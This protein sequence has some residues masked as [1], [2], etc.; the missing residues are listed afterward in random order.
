MKIKLT[1]SQY[2]KMLL[3]EFGEIVNDPKDWYVR[4]LDWVSS[5]AELEFDSN[6]Y[7]VVVYDKKWTIKATHLAA[8]ALLLWKKSLKTKL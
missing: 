6:N 3:R 7:E 2:K 1:E 8:E 5:P 4:I